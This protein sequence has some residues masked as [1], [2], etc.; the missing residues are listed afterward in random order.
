MA[1][2]GTPGIL[3]SDLGSQ[4]TNREYRKVL[5]DFHITQS[6]D[7]KSRWVDNSIIGRWFRSL[8]TEEIYVTEYPSLECLPKVIAAYIHQYY[9]IHPYEAFNYET[10]ERTFFEL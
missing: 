5:Q 3:N 4:F 10:S 2:H 6:M 8:M 9:T 7:G 1:K